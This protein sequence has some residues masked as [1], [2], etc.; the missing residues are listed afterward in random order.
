MAV[1]VLTGRFPEAFD[2]G[3]FERWFAVWSAPEK[4]DGKPKLAAARMA[5]CVLKAALTFGKGR[6]YP[7]CAELKSILEDMRFASLKPRQVAPTAGQ[8]IALRLAARAAGA[9]LRALAYALQFETTLRQWD[10]IGQWVPLK[11][12]RPSTLFGYGEKWIGPT[13]ARIDDD[14]VLKLTPTKTED[15]SEARVSFDLRECPMVLEEMVAIPAHQRTGSL[16]IN[17]RTGLPYRH[18]TWRELWREDRAAAGLPRH[19]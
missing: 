14:L 9:P 19:V 6:R 17:E 15:T 7:G 13:W 16:I 2:A 12:P 10:V 5:I 3:D 11:D 1:A 8:V 4:P 18:D